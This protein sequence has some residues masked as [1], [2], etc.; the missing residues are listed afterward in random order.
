MKLT[1]KCYIYTYLIMYGMQIAY[2]NEWI[3]LIDPYVIGGVLF[4]GT[5]ASLITFDL[6]HLEKNI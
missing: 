1:I 3:S 5:I 6:K 4:F 2:K